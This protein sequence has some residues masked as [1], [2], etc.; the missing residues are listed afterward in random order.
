MGKA[1]V[2]LNKDRYQVLQLASREFLDP[3]LRRYIGLFN[4]LE[5]QREGLDFEIEDMMKEID[6]EKHFTKGKPQLTLKDLKPED[7]LAILIAKIRERDSELRENAQRIEAMSKMTGALIKLHL[8]QIAGEDDANTA[9]QA[10]GSPRSPR[11]P[12]TAASEVGKK[13]PFA[14]KVGS[15]ERARQKKER[16]AGELALMFMGINQVAFDL[17]IEN[18]MT[19]YM[20]EV[21]FTRILGHDDVEQG[22]YWADTTLCYICQKWE[23]CTIQFD[24]RTDVSSWTLK[25]VQINNLQQTIQNLNDEAVEAEEI[26]ASELRAILEEEAA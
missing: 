20:N 4:K 26:V 1:E 23:K 7:K 8:A 18:P 22:N 12:Q 17:L 10:D 2:K 9:S 14:K 5:Q 3:E 11:S 24:T 16:S 15:G 13:N 19:G 6:L 25:I 21:I